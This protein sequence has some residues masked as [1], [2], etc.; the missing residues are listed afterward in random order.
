[1]FCVAALSLLA[2]SSCYDDSSLWNEFDA[3]HGELDDLKE[4]IEKLEK[5]LNEKIDVLSK[6]VTALD[7]AYKAADADLLKKLQD[8]DAELAASINTLTTNLDALDGKVDGYIKSNDEALAAA[9]QKYQDDLKK[10]ADDMTA[11]DKLLAEADAEVLKALVAVGVTKVEKNADGNAVLTFTDGTTLVVGAYDA[12]ANNTGVVTVVEVEGV[13]YWAV[14]LEDGTKESL[15]IPVSHTEIDFKVGED[16]FLY[17]SVNGG[18]WVSTG[19]YVADDQDSLIDFYWG[20]TDEIDWD[21][22]EYIKEDFYTLVFGG[23]TYYLPIYKVDNS[24]VSLK[25]GKTYFEYGESVTVDVV[26][27][28][29]T[30]VYVMTKP[31]GWRASLVGKK[32]TVTAPAEDAVEAGYAEA[33]GE[34]LLHATTAEGK[35]K[36]VKFA[37]ATTPG[38]SL[39]VTDDGGLIIVNPEVVTM[40]NMWGEELTDFNDAYIGLADLADFEANPTAYV[41]G[42]QDNW[43]AVYTYINNWKGNTAD[44]DEDW[45]PIYTI[46]GAYEP[47]VYEVDVI[48]TTVAQFYA[49]LKWGQEI[50]AQPYVVWACPMDESGMPRVEDL[51]YA[52]YYPAVKATITEVTVS[53]TDVEVAINVVGATTYYVGLVTEE[54]TYG[55]P[56]DDYMQMQEGPFG[57]FQMALQYG[58]PEYAF[59][60][61]GTQF[62]GEYGEEMTETITASMIN[63]GQPLMPSTKFYMWV[64]PVVDGLD[65]A[66]YTYADNLKPY[67]YEFTT[68]GLSAGG[69]ATVEFSNPALTYTSM[70]VDLTATAGSTMIYYK[71]FDEDTYNS[72][73]DEAALAEELIANGYALPGEEGTARNSDYNITPGSEYFLVALAVDADGKYGETVGKLY[74]APEIEFSTTFTATFGEET[75]AVYYSGYQYNF[76]ITVT[77]GTAAKYYYVWSTTEYS[78]EDLANLP[79][80]YDYNYNFKSTTSGVSEGMLKGQ[81][82]NAESTYYLAVVVESTDGELSAVIK[83][84]VTV[85]AVPTEE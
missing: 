65:L 61:M 76:P 78:D 74:A 5:D 82:A 12:N 62:G 72:F 3:V 24:V 70:S 10:L 80:T 49:D 15:G 21:T 32:L 9:I 17:Y 59:Q 26:I 19:A 30:S 41:E 7:A 83:K 40:T 60:Q 64:F 46:G 14:V 56:I 66:D 51:V 44:M 47:G 11:A 39:T 2:V 8:G 25:A 1:M 37:V 18:E 28:D 31:D 69:S 75:S 81:Y 68:E 22:Y 34:V 57:Y 29:I 55:F 33:D 77:G 84:T 35:C 43:D 20:E 52:Y 85:P 73:A 71:W 50:P 27:S 16:N 4:R 6:T 53:T 79:L 67:I 13:K 38:F 23:Q 36:I 54:M 58:M 45:N 48:E 63:Y 42:I